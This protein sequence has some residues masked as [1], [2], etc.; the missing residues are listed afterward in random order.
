MESEV[1][2]KVDIKFIL[3]RVKMTKH[4]HFVL[5]YFFDQFN[6]V[7]NGRMTVVKFAELFGLIE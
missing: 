5:T 1:K 4:Q 6:E 3:K 2:R 7:L